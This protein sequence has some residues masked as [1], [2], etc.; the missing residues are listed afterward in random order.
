MSRGRELLKNTGILMLAKVSTQIVNFLL[1]PLYTSILA[2]EEYGIMDIYTSMAMI[3]VPVVTLQIEMALFRFF[4]VSKN[5][6]EEEQIVSSSFALIAMMLVLASI[7]YSIFVSLFSLS[8]TLLLYL[9]YLS[10]IITT[11]L[12]QCSRA[13]GDNIGYGIGSFLISSVAIVSNVLLLCVF[14]L[15]VEG[16]ILSTIIAQLISS[17]FLVSRTAIYR[18]FKLSKISILE[19]KKL[20]SYSIPLVF[21][22]IASW[23]INYSNRLII[24]SFWGSG[25]NGIY[26][27]ANKFSNVI[28]TFFGVFNV[29]W[30]ENVIRSIQDKDINYIGKMYT[31][32]SNVY[33]I[34]IT[35]VLNCLPFVWHLLVD[36]SYSKSY[37]QVPILLLAMYFS[38]MAATLGSIYI[39]E[40][41]TKEVSVTTILTGVINI[42]VHLLF[43]NNLKLYAASISSLIA[44]L[45]LFIFRLFNIKK[46]VSFK[47]NFRDILPRLII[48]IACSILFVS[49]NYILIGCG[50]TVNIIQFVM[51]SIKNRQE[52]LKLI[53]KQK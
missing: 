30:T 29:A 15:K 44:F 48:M 42:A 11:V 9:F 52:I 14:H 17:F 33:C 36:S 5:R 53:R 51:L 7:I 12:L 39:A 50:L 2:T 47:V 37:N 8:D 22:Q 40:G 35:G 16:M 31:I 19:C 25:I 32:I 26:S 4:I 24:L 3:I 49:N 34:L 46:I 41:R 6:D 45:I 28:N 13:K 23:V 43:I 27:V 20:L 21:N 18:W 1:L 38:G 10:Q